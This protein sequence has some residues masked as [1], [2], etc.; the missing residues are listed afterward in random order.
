MFT[1]DIILDEE[2]FKTASDRL[3]ILSDDMQKLK[4]RIETLMAELRKGFDTP[5]GE[6][7]FELC[8][9][10]LIKPLDDQ[11]HVIEHVAQN[12]QDARNSYSSVFYEYQ[13]LN[14]A[15]SNAKQ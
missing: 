14:S 12:L 11:A 9:S 4:K 10:N 6:K 13:T 8:G 1:K 3:K 7:F 15:I 2:A 5:A